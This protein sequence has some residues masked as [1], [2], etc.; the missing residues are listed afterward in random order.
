MLKRLKFLFF[1][2]III[3]TFIYFSYHR[4][5]NVSL[6]ETCEDI[7]FVVKEGESVNEIAKNLEE[8]N[9]ISSS[10]YF[11][12][13]VW[14]QEMESKFKAGDYI[15]NPMLTIKEI[16]DVLIKGRTQSKEKTVKIIEGWNL[17]NISNYFN[18]NNFFQDVDLSQTTL[19]DL[20]S[21]NFDITDFDFLSDS[22]S[23]SNLEGY[24]FPD[25][26]RIF[27]DAKLEDVIY[28]M[29]D[30]FDKKLD[31]DMRAEIERQDKTIYEILTMASIVEKE[32]RNQE[33]MEIVAG[34]FWDRIKNGQALQSC[35]SLA[36]IL[37][38]NKAQYT[39]EDT[40]IDSPYNTYQNQGLP[41]GPICNPGIN[42]IKA[43]IYSEYTDYNYFLS[44]PDTGETVF[45]STYDEHLRNKAKYLD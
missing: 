21:K 18:D 13:Y 11:E 25:T 22:R 32:V 3:F 6:C 23:D 44:R 35:A 1:L 37:G 24:L 10:F 40:Q 30:N 33:D 36:Y 9:L 17:R 15:L 7:D 34:I 31:Q 16:V 43:S 5:I 20:K 12:V 14:Q 28:K 39:L 8:N 38:V 29:L 42:A 2:V 45:S 19:A 26:Y 27:E 4:A 41:P